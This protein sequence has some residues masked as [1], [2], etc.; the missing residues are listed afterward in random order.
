ME[1]ALRWA[2]VVG[3]GG[4]DQLAEAVC[5]TM[6][7]SQFDHGTFWESVLHFF[8]NNPL[9]DVAHVGPIVDYVQRQ[10]FG[11]NVGPGEGPGEAARA[12]GEGDAQGSRN[13]AARD[14][15]GTGA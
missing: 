10:R 11:E 1:M 7:G 4:D 12:A 8:V 15:T 13:A 3:M 5:E 2:Q 9:L 14:R 6:L